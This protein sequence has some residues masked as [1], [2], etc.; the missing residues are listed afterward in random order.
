MESY[1]HIDVNGDCPWNDFESRLSTF[2]SQIFY[3][4][5]NFTDVTAE[6]FKP[7][8]VYGFADEL[9]ER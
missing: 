2:D 9:A 6:D 7:S 4:E 3:D 8:D 5:Y 1:F